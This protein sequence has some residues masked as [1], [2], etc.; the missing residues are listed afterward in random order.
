M[1][2]FIAL[3]MLL[4]AGLQACDSQFVLPGGSAEPTLPPR[5]TA[6]DRPS[7]SIEVPPPI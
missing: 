1:V 6:P 2:R 4:L 7:P 5:P 3:A